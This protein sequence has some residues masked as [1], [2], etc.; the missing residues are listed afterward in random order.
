VVAGLSFSCV[1]A[2]P[3]HPSGHYFYMLADE[4]GPEIWAI[5][6]D[7]ATGALTNPP[8]PAASLSGLWSTFVLVA[9]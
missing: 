8:A 3:L 1:A 2:S 6:I 4:S 7:P 5:G 9:S